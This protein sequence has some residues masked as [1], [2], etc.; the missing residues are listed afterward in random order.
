MVPKKAKP[1]SPEAVKLGD[2]IRRRR[3]AIKVS[4]DEFADM[5]GMHRSYIGFVERGM[6]NLTLDTMTRV[7]KALKVSLAVLV[8]EAGI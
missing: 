8:K 6:Q 1:Y 2:A 4:Q 3:Q 5:A 7:A